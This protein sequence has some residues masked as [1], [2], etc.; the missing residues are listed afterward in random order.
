MRYTREMFK[1]EWQIEPTSTRKKQSCY[2][3]KYKI[4]YIEEIVW[5]RG[6]DLLGWE[7][8]GF[9]DTE[10]PMEWVEQQFVDFLNA[11]L[12]PNPYEAA[13]KELKGQIN[14]QENINT[15]SNRPF[16]AVANLMTRLELTHKVESHD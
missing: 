3:D 16:K 8:K 10:E 5:M 6:T 13:W 15:Y 12:P 4:G 2:V 14:F 11:V 9:R 1:F 7:S